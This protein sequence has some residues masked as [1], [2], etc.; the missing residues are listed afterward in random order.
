MPQKYLLS[1]LSLSD[2]LHCSC[3]ILSPCQGWASSRFQ[4]FQSRCWI[5]APPHN[6]QLAS[7]SQP[8]NQVLAC[9]R[10]SWHAWQWQPYLSVPL[11]AAGRGSTTTDSFVL[12]RRERD[13]QTPAEPA[14]EPRPRGL[15]LELA[16]SRKSGGATRSHLPGAQLQRPSTTTVHAQPPPPSPSLRNPV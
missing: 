4:K 15:E 5:H 11:A 7:A 13:A 2:S 10:A 6:L 14:R 9:P 16:G 8:Q 1:P 12:I 3:L